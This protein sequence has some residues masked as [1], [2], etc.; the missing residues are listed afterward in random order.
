MGPIAPNCVLPGT[1]VPDRPVVAVDQCVA[2]TVAE[3]PEAADN[4]RDLINDQRDL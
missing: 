3:T 4:A 2:L 1:S